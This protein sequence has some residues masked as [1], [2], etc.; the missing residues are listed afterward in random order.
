MANFIEIRPLSREISRHVI[1][2]V[3]QWR[4]RT[5]GRADAWDTQCLRRL[6]LAMG[7]TNYNI[8]LRIYK[9]NETIR[10]TLLYV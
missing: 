2:G 1:T 7:H 9:L 3:W 10:L 4:E 8:K 5:D 6:L